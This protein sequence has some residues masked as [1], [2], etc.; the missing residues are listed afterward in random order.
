MNVN[1][2]VQQLK[3]ERDRLDAAIR[4]LENVGGIAPIGVKRRGRP[5][6]TTNKPTA[7][8]GSKRRSMSSAARKRIADA[9]KARW[10]AAKKSGRKKL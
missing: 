8:K 5:P 6:G 4:A 2:V 1:E 7:A 9:M 3:A 10:A